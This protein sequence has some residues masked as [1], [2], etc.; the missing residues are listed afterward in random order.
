[1]LQAPWHSALLGGFGLLPSLFAANC[2]I[3]ALF[4]P[5]DTDS[6]RF[7]FFFFCLAERQ[8]EL[9]AISEPLSFSADTTAYLE[10]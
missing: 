10:I 1:M 9:H 5:G 8:K 3:D 7:R 4:L 6:S 2:L